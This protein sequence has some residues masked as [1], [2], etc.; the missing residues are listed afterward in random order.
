MK[1]VKI[2]KYHKNEKY[3]VVYLGNG[4]CHNFTQDR[5]AKRFLAI[6]SKFLTKSLYDLRFVFG[7]ITALYIRNWAYFK[8]NKAS[9]SHRHIVDEN[10]CKEA[11]RSVEDSF[12]LIINRCQYTNGNYFAFQKQTLIVRYLKDVVLKLDKLHKTK[13]NAV[14]RFEFDAIFDRLQSIEKQLNNY[15]QAKAYDLFTLPIHIGDD[16]REFIPE[17]KITA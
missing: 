3:F 13:S 15:H 6:T 10:F 11:I 14:D 7:Q 8:H 5:Q 17:L 4:T 1:H 16:Q 2:S 9:M 12:D